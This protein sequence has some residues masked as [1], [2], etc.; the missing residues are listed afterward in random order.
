[1]AI[2]S[3]VSEIWYTFCPV[4]CVS[5]IAQNKG[6]L[7]EE[8]AKNSIKISH[9][10]CLPAEN[11]QSHFSHEHPVLFREGGNIPPIWARSESFATK[12]VGMTWSED[13][14]VIMVR[15]DSPIQSVKELKGKKIALPRRLPNLIDWRRA[16][17]KRG[18]IMSLLAHELTEDDIQFVDLPIDIPDIAKEKTPGRTGAAAMRPRIWQGEPAPEVEALEKGEVDAIYTFNG[19]DFAL[20]E[21]GIARAIYNLDKHPDWKYHI[22]QGYPY[23]CTVSTDFAT[24]HPDLIVKW[25]KVMVRAGIWARDNYTEVVRIMAEAMKLPEDTFRKAFPPIFTNIWSLRSQ[26]KGWRL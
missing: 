11:W 10:S 21:D 18:I 20:E 6:W 1:M 9:I 24:E 4:V 17:I 19:R 2:T 8:F 13:R 26:I 25:M 3:E 7:T 15:K 23:I 16:V 5:H 22:S 14:Q 12:V